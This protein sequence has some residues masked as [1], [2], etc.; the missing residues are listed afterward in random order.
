[1]IARVSLHPVSSIEHIGVQTGVCD[2]SCGYQE[3]GSKAHMKH[4]ISMCTHS[5][6]PHRNAPACRAEQIGATAHDLDLAERDLVLGD[7]CQP[8]IACMAQ[9]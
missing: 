1:M 2:W 4:A 3:P 8:L 5:Q 9:S 6:K 7:D